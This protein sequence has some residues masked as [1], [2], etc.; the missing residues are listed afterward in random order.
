MKSLSPG[1]EYRTKRKLTNRQRL[2]RLIEATQD[3]CDTEVTA[4][5]RRLTKE[6][7]QIASKAVAR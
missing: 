4:I 2:E 7:D 3:G 1:Q 5:F 6:L